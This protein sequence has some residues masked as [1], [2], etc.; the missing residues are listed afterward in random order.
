MKTK[1]RK[2]IRAWAFLYT[3]KAQGAMKYAVFDQREKKPLPHR[4]GYGMKLIRVELTVV[5]G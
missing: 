2:K 4:V 3:G 1:K 5:R